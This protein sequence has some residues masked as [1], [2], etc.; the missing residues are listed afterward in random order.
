MTH[1]LLFGISVD[2]MANLLL[3]KWNAKLYQW[4]WRSGCGKQSPTSVWPP[5]PLEAAVGGGPM[6]STNGALPLQRGSTQPPTNLPSLPVSLRWL[7]KLPRLPDPEVQAGR[8]LGRA[9]G[10]DP[11]L[12]QGPVA[13]PGSWGWIFRRCSPHSPPLPPSVGRK[14]CGTCTSAHHQEQPACLTPDTPML[15]P[16]QQEG[17]CGAVFQ[18]TSHSCNPGES[19]MEQLNFSSTDPREI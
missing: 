5:C 13:R 12:S 10:K 7:L 18:L 9:G 14:S 1:Q 2:G 6:A 4:K 11:G 8:G 15:P 19:I 17:G 3:W 16:G